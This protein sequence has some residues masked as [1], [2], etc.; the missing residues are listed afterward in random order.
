MT[1]AGA[2]PVTGSWRPG[3]I[4]TRPLEDVALLAEGLLFPE[5]PVAMADGS[6]LV[7][8][9]D[10]ATV[11]RVGPGGEVDVV[12]RCDGGPNGAAIGP[13]GW[14]YV[15]N[16]GGRWASGNWT[17]G[18]IEK[19]D[20]ATGEVEAVYRDCDGRRLSGP[21]DIVFDS[22]GRFW[23]TDTGKFQGRVRDV[24][25]VY[26]ASVDGDHIAEVVHPAESPNGVGLSPDGTVLYYAETVTGRLRRR[27]ITRPG[28]LRPPDGHG[29]ET[30]VCG[31]PGHQPLDSLAVD[32]G[33]NI[34]VATFLTGCITVVSPDGADVVQ[35]TLPDGLA[36]AMPTNLCF[37]GDDLTTAY[38]TLAGTGRIVTCRWPTPGLRLEYNG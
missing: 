12:A 28:Q 1:V 17:G 5:G 19:V 21:N 30:L 6:V 8:E 15:C 25:S 37:G 13:D 2:P 38:I 34:C 24:G 31:L 32:A 9:I 27:T 35:Y 14:L 33:G 26:Y 20:L 10:R 11:T 4:P 23:F 3:S 18:W 36:D 22:S 16:N 7:T 29:L